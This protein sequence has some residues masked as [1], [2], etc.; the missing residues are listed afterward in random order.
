MCARAL[1]V[2]NFAAARYRC[3]SRPVCCS[4]NR[5]IPTRNPRATP[6][7][8]AA[9]MDTL[10]YWIYTIGLALAVAVVMLAG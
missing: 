6:K 5:Q 3:N 1:D 2:F 9:E 10:D 4:C 8:H 7:C